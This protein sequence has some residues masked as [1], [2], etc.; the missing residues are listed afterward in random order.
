MCLSRVLDLS[1]IVWNMI[2]ICTMSSS[3]PSAFNFVNHMYV[4][5]WMNVVVVVCENKKRRILL[6][7]SSS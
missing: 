1:V 4:D 7:L 5:G 6:L 3:S 2:C